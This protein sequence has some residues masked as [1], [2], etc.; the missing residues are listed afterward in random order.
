MA[1]LDGVQ[2]SAA[3]AT[4]VALEQGLGKDLLVGGVLDG[5]AHLLLGGI[6]AHDAV[7]A[8]HLVLQLLPEGRIHALV[9]L[10]GGLEL[11]VDLADL[12]GVL[13]RAGVGLLLEGADAAG[14]VAVHGHGL[15]GDG[16]ELTVGGALF[17]GVGVVEGALLE[18][19]EVAQAILDSVDAIIDIAALVQDVVGVVL[20][21][22]LGAVGGEGFHLDVLAWGIGSVWGFMVIAQRAPGGLYT[23]IL[24]TAHGGTIVVLVA[25]V[26]GGCWRAVGLRIAARGSTGRVSSLIVGV[27]ATAISVR[28]DG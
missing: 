5:L 23:G 28:G 18:D 7:L 17:G 15:G 6:R 27:G 20:L 14:E 10:D 2:R 4:A 3:L 25:V 16:V 13:G 12:R 21:S 19:G 22:E 9:L 11:A 1:V 26:V 24:V 8:G